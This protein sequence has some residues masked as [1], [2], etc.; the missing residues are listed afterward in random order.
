MIHLFTGDDSK[1]KLQAYEKFI[2]STSAQGEIF[3]INRNDFNPI[4]IES[5]YSGAGLFSPKCIVVFSNILDGKETRD[6]ILKKLEPLQLSSNSFVFLEGKLAKT[7]LD[8]FKKSK[9]EVN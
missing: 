2:K 1:N 4:Q 6:F 7:A 3:F 8:A 9:A 5:F